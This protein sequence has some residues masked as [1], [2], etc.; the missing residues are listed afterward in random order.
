MSLLRTVGF[1]AKSKFK[2]RNLMAKYL[3]YSVIIKKNES[4]ISNFSAMDPAASFAI[5]MNDEKLNNKVV[6]I[7]MFIK[8]QEKKEFE[9]G[10]VPVIGSCI[11]FADIDK[12]EY[13][14]GSIKIED[15]EQQ[16]LENHIIKSRAASFGIAPE[17]IITKRENGNRYH[18][19]LLKIGTFDLN[20]LKIIWNAVNE[21]IGSP[22]IDTNCSAIRIEGFLKYNKDHLA[23]EKNSRYLPYKP[24]DMT[25]K[26]L[27]T[28]CWLEPR[29][30][31]SNQSKISYL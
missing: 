8:L 21:D 14:G 29:S 13:K 2:T 10:L 18:I 6:L 26:Q 7:E 24:A 28:K 20:I 19:Y 31:D 25:M 4:R 30:V 27:L 12:L 16:I 15:V 3:S 1:C 5:D 11:F 23:Y 9:F 17:V 22:V